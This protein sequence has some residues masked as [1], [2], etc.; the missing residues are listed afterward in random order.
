[1]RV[2]LWSLR[3]RESDRVHELVNRDMP[4]AHG[5]RDWYPYN[6]VHEWG[7]KGKV[8]EVRL[9]GDYEIEILL[10]KNDI[11][12]LISAAWGEKPFSDFIAAMSKPHPLD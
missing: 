1:M 9:N 10:N 4:D 12:S 5:E 3:G 6:L 11:A 7:W 8:T 2:K